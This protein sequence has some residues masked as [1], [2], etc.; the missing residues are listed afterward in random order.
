MGPTLL[1]RSTHRIPS[2]R[3]GPWRCSLPQLSAN[4]GAD[5]AQSMTA[6]MACPA[7]SDALAFAPPP[8]QTRKHLAPMQARLG[9]RDPFAP[10]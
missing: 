2:S 10:A 3:R 8:A 9:R 5:P 1:R 4:N 7:R 6:T